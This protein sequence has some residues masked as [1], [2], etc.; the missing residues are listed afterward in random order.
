M[1]AV[2][3]F[4][5]LLFTEYKTLGLDEP[6]VEIP[7]QIQQASN[8]ALYVMLAMLSAELILKYM[9]IRN[10]RQFLKKYWL[11]V[12]MVILIPVFSGIKIFKTVQIAKKAKII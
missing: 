9:K 5:V 3:Y 1:L 8:I 10:M 12:T 11:D 2:F 6:I 7:I 4:G